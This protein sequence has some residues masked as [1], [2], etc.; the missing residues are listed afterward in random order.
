MSL[1]SMAGGGTVKDIIDAGGEVLDNLFTSDKERLD[2]DNETRRL[3]LAEKE[4]EQ[5][6]QIEQI[7]TNRQEAKSGNWFTAGW[8]PFTGWLCGLLMGVCVGAQIIG[9]FMGVDYT[10]MAIIYGST[11]APVHLGILGLRSY[12]KKT[13][14]A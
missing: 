11:V 7:K 12:E 10:A 6:G 8:R 4:I 5:R 3:G 1:F 13:G 2:A 9:V 14:V